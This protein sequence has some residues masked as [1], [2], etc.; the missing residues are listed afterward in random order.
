LPDVEIVKSPPEILL[1]VEYGGPAQARLVNLQNKTFKEFI[2]RA[3]GKT[4]DCIMIPAMYVVIV[5]SADYVAVG[6]GLIHVP[7]SI[8]FPFGK[9]KRNDRKNE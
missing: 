9:N 8:F 3:D 7:I 1:F 2:I 4:I 5:E 6:G